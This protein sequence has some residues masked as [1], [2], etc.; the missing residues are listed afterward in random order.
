MVWLSPDEH[1]FTADN[2][3]IIIWKINNCA[4]LLKYETEHK[5]VLLH[6]WIDDK[7]ITNVKV[8]NKN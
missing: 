4:I 1:C 3:L 6:K 8:W 2:M 7:I 5:H